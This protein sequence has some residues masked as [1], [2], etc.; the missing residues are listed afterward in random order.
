M[1]KL[2]SL[3]FILS[4]QFQF[5]YCLL[6]INLC[7]LFHACLHGSDWMLH[8]CN[9]PDQH[10]QDEMKTCLAKVLMFCLL[11]F[12]VFTS[13]TPRKDIYPSTHLSLP[14]LLPHHLLHFFTFFFWFSI[15]LLFC[16]SC[17]LIEYHHFIHLDVCGEKSKRKWISINIGFA[18]T[19][20][21]QM[22]KETL[23]QSKQR[24]QNF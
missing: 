10:V 7:S 3:E 6:I 13:V 15:S 16:C 20:N 19:C 24:S 23:L 22:A 4:H 2:P 17:F 18:E 8:R 21:G 12:V 9:T 14:F 1:R 5:G 11:S